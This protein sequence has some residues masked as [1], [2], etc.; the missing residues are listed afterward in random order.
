MATVRDL[1]VSAV[2]STSVCEL[3][4]SW[5]CVAGLYKFVF[6]S[7]LKTADVLTDWVCEEVLPSVQKTGTYT[8]PLLPQTQLLSKTDL[9]YKV[10]DCMSHSSLIISRPSMAKSDAN[11]N[12][13]TKR[14]VDKQ[15]GMWECSRTCSCQTERRFTKDSP[16]N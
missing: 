15:K 9:H 14:R 16:S 1:C 8:V 12:P 3:Q 6:K 11:H 13:S 4:T 10:L 5:T 7:Q 2:G